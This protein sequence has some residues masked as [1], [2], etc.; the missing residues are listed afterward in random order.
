MSKWWIHISSTLLR[1]RYQANSPSARGAAIRASLCSDW[2]CNQIARAMLALRECN[3]YSVIHGPGSELQA[4][5]P[6]Y[7]SHQ[8]PR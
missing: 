4:E 6:D 1:S 7:D 2:A 8:V 3:Y 5:E